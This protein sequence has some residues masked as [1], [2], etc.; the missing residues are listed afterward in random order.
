M[1]DNAIKLKIF[2]RRFTRIKA[3][4][5]GIMFFSV[6][7]WVLLAVHFPLYSGAFIFIY[8]FTILLLRQY[9]ISNMASLYHG[10]RTTFIE[11]VKYRGYI[12]KALAISIIIGFFRVFIEIYYF[13]HRI[14]NFIPYYIFV[15]I[16]NLLLLC[17][18]LVYRKITH[19]S[20]LFNKTT[21][22]AGVDYREIAELLQ[23]KF[24]ITGVSVRILKN[25]K[26]RLFNI[27]SLLINKNSSF[28]VFTRDFSG[29]LAREET[30]GI[31]AHEMAHIKNKD[32]YRFFIVYSMLIFL[33][34]DI[35]LVPYIFDKGLLLISL[36]I[37]TII[38]AIFATRIPL[39]LYRRKREIKADITATKYGFG[40]SLI[41]GIEIL[42]SLN[43]YPIQK[44]KG[45]MSTHYS[46][47]ERKK[48]IEEYAGNY[49]NSAKDEINLH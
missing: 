47:Q 38:L 4:F 23:K 6:V 32:S 25:N 17:L 40:F 20:N 8:L 9:S 35:L 36:A 46:F 28:M 24:E 12:Y 16:L 10:T 48:K 7:L 29:Y 1:E 31:M 19:K 18:I 34:M 5:A 27:F 37:D 21:V 41:K 43:V 49:I 33:F 11:S 26:Y 13:L 15:I 2:L 14:L 45:I 39:L 42:D 30:I 44:V 22:D 3:I